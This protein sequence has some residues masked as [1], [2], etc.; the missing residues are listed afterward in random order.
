MTNID[1]NDDFD[2]DDY[3]DPEPRRGRGFLA[4]DVSIICKAYVNGEYTLKEGKFMSPYMVAKLLKERDGLEK[5]PSSGAIHKI[6]HH[7]EDIGYATFRQTPYAF[8]DFTPE[9]RD[10]TLQ[11]FLKKHQEEHG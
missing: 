10:M 9:G 5:Q 2:P 4:T 11:D 6:F 1:E 3:D 7:W 8:V